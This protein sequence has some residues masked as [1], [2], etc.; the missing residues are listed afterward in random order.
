MRASLAVI[1]DP[2]VW[3]SKVEDGVR[4]PPP[5]LALSLPEHRQL[6]PWAVLGI[7]EIQNQNPVGGQETICLFHLPA[8]T[9]P[10]PDYGF[11]KS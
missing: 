10:H 6:C 1:R 5:P 7:E 8:P 9:H 4:H 2:Q 11:S 3:P